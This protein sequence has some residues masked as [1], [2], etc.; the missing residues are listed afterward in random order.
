[1]PGPELEDFGQDIEQKFRSGNV[2][3][4]EQF[5]SGLDYPIDKDTLLDRV[6]SAGAREDLLETL[7]TL[8]DKRFGS[9]EEIRESL[10]LSM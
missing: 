5:L 4:I 3:Q 7:K 10:G 8:P 2:A 9:F 6:R 1:M